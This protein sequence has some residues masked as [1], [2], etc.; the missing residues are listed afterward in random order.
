MKS[1][2]AIF[3]IVLMVSLSIL[4]P[5]LQFTA[6]AEEPEPNEVKSEE[7]NDVS[8]GVKVATEMAGNAVNYSNLLL[9]F[10]SSSSVSNAINGALVVTGLAKVV[11]EAN[12]TVNDKVSSVSGLIGDTGDVVGKSA[13]TIWA[14]KDS[15]SKLPTSIQNASASSNILQ[16]FS[17]ITK[18]GYSV[19]QGSIGTP[20]SIL[21]SL[22]NASSNAINHVKGISVVNKVLAPLAAVGAIV[23][24]AGAFNAVETV[25]KV[26]KSLSGV[27]NLLVLGAFLAAGTAGAPLLAIGALTTGIVALGIKYREPIKKAA[28]WAWNRI[29]TGASKAWSGI[30]TGA[31]AT[32]NFISSNA[33]IGFTFVKDKL[34]S[35]K[36]YVK[37]KSAE[38]GK[39]IS[40]VKN[41]IVSAVKKKM[42]S[43]KK[44]LNSGKN[45]VISAAKKVTSTV[46]KKASAAKKTVVSAAKKATSSVKKKTSGLFKKVSK[47]W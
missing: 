17:T 25:D 18:H 20:V 11:S 2:M 26:E 27:S 7:L 32:Y 46:K 13:D 6:L 40:S 10:D 33:S 23:D 19:L 24:F 38:F 47:I 22:K 16:Q 44:V 42:N 45:K 31:K 3:S 15:F 21:D 5:Y 30:K 4:F 1:K 14:V 34:S 41:T 12:D 35:A 37:K 39:K 43:A 9:E 28:T 36:N 29:K 8:T